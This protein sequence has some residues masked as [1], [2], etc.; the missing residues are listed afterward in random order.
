V[1]Y[2]PLKGTDV[3][4]SPIH[5]QSGKRDDQERFLLAHAT[6]RLVSAHVPCRAPRRADTRNDPHVYA[7]DPHTPMAT[8]V[9]S[10]TI[11]N[12]VESK[13]L[14]FTLHAE[15]TTPTTIPLMLLGSLLAHA[16]MHLVLAHVP[17]RAARRADMHNEPHVYAPDPH[18]SMA[19][20]VGSDTI[21]NALKTKWL[22]FI[23]H[24]ERTTPTTIPLML[25]SSLRVKGLTRKWWDGL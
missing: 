22:R 24:A 4:V 11:C 14:R 6:V 10:D 13:R 8:K 18:V 25:L 16:T 15:Q 19:A 17:C 2:T 21:C 9:T 23:L 20:K 3:L 12:T 1:T 7:P 5:P